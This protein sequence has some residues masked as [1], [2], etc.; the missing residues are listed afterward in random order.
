MSVNG[1]GTWPV[2]HGWGYPTTT[3]SWSGQAAPTTG[4]ENAVYSQYQPSPTSYDSFGTFNAQHSNSQFQNVDPSGQPVYQ[5]TNDRLQLPSMPRTETVKD[6]KIT[7]GADNS[8]HIQF[9]GSS[10]PSSARERHQAVSSNSNTQYQMSGVSNERTETANQ[11]YQP[12]IQSQQEVY[13]AVSADSRS[14][15]EM[16]QH[17]TNI[18]SQA[19]TNPVVKA[20]AARNKAILLKAFLIRQ[21]LKLNKR[22]GKDSWSQTDI[23][24]NV[25]NIKSQ[26]PTN[27]EVKTAE[28]RTK[29]IM[30]RRL[31]LRKLSKLNKKI[32]EDQSAFRRQFDAQPKTSAQNSRKVKKQ[33]SYKTQHVNPA[34]SSESYSVKADRQ[35]AVQAKFDVQQSAKPS[36]LKQLHVYNRPVPSA[37]K[38]LQAVAQR[39]SVSQPKSYNKPKSSISNR[40]YQP[41]SSYKPPPSAS[42]F[43]SVL[44]SKQNTVKGLRSK[45]KPVPS[46]TAVGSVSPRPV[47]RPSKSKPNFKPVQSVSASISKAP[48]RPKEGYRPKYN[49]NSLPTASSFRYISPSLRKRPIRHKS[50]LKPVPEA[51]ATRSAA[52]R[53]RKKVDPPQS[54][55]I[56]VPSAPSFKAV[57]SSRNSRI[58]QPKTNLKTAPSA[59]AFRYVSF[60]QRNRSNEAPSASAFRYDIPSQHSRANKPKT[61]SNP[62][63]SSNRYI[64]PSIVNRDEQPQSNLKTVASVSSNKAVSSSQPNSAYRPRQRSYS[65][66][67]PKAS[68]LK[69]GIRTNFKPKQKDRANKRQSYTKY[70]KKASSLRSATQR[71]VAN[72]RQS[73][74]QTATGITNA[75]SATSRNMANQLKSY[76]QFRPMEVTTNAGPVAQEHITEL[77]PLP[78]IQQMPI[79]TNM[80]T[81]TQM[82]GAYQPQSNIQSERNVA[83]QSEMT[84]TYQ[85]QS[86]IQPSR[87]VHPPTDI[88]SSYQSQQNSQLLPS[89][90]SRIYQSQSSNQPTRNAAVPTRNAAAPSNIN[91]AYQPQ[92]NTQPERNSVVRSNTASIYQQQSNI[93]PTRNAAV[94][95]NVASINQPQSNIQSQMNA[96][97]HSDI[98]SAYQA[99]SNIQPEL[100]TAIRSNIA[101]AY[102]AQSNIQPDSGIALRSNLANAYQAQSNIQPTVAAQGKTEYQ[103]RSI[104]PVQPTAASIR[105][106]NIV[107]SLNNKQPA[108]GDVKSNLWNIV[109][110]FLKTQ[111][112]SDLQALMKSPNLLNS[113]KAL[114]GGK[115]PS[116]QPK[117]TVYEPVPTQQETIMQPSPQPQVNIEHIWTSVSESNQAVTGQGQP[118][119]SYVLPTDSSQVWSSKER[120]RPSDIQSGASVSGVAIDLSRGAPKQAD[121][122]FNNKET[123]PSKAHFSSVSASSYS[124]IKQP[125]PQYKEESKPKVLKSAIG[126]AQQDIQNIN[127]KP[128]AIG[129][130]PS[131]MNSRQTIADTSYMSAGNSKPSNSMFPYRS[132][133]TDAY[134]KPAESVNLSGSNSKSSNSMFPYRSG[135]TS[136]Y[137]SN[138]YSPQ[139]S[140]S[141]PP[142]SAEPSGGN[143][144]TSNSMFPY[145]SGGTSVYKSNDYSPQTLGHVPPPSAE[146]SGGN[147]KTSNS[148]FPY[149][150]GGINVYQSNAYAKQ[151]AEPIAS[152]PWDSVYSAPKRESKTAT[153]PVELPPWERPNTPA[154]LPIPK[155]PRPPALDF[156]TSRPSRRRPMGPQDW[157]PGLTSDRPTSK[158]VQ[159]LWSPESYITGTTG[160]T[161]TLPPTTTTSTTILTTTLPPNTVPT[162]PQVAPYIASNDH[163]GGGIPRPMASVTTRRPRKKFKGPIRIRPMKAGDPPNWDA[164]DVV[165]KSIVS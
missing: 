42:S 73:S 6:R 91:S 87:K 36:V 94:R 55:S 145:R 21:V 90:T 9:T 105:K 131:I 117:P 132:G 62:A 163:P 160:A 138:D 151:G 128:D 79:A 32:A 34:K 121:T 76:F 129:I 122:G 77:P 130:N 16:Y 104:P 38:Q 114:S 80:R 85:A 49:L 59:S 66:P 37:P 108:E 74:F 78:Y 18:E 86:N 24:Q 68:Y 134:A 158:N 124:D 51:P 67:A 103:P 93:Q 157:R 71:D 126:T 26:T 119:D 45:S 140:G 95:P 139:T 92:L 156:N 141:V 159:Y 148:M 29:A 109:K 40:P 61:N 113:L 10:V 112:L 137:K 123:V 22:I 153:E 64:S 133:G 152:A 99:L 56:S 14:Q 46:K 41:K 135:G 107:Q 63:V 1:Q 106:T 50:S 3:P 102:Q 69:S 111:S 31:L 155:I 47:N 149:R 101:S 58:N 136:V 96:A 57:A 52:S 23:Y 27:P 83:I 98:A 75:K 48:R 43:R 115:A 25:T 161:P 110:T 154:P 12:Q 19:S 70:G 2:Q 142:P 164:F 7:Y 5:Q 8:I 81:Y 65:K 13:P 116:V 39:N 150:A 84:G 125:K 44:P 143:P 162:A 147:S 97:V 30:F 54:L 60:S 53:Q 17:L 35:T 144:K 82:N 127:A 165:G 11:I 118:Y 146:P 72:K 15:A 89:A 33:T 120:R 88:G 28:A 100:N 4:P 20:A